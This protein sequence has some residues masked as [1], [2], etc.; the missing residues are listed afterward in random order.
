MAEL[1]QDHDDS[2]PVPIVLIDQDS[3]TNATVVELSFGDRLGA[4]L[5]T[6]LYHAFDPLFL[7]MIHFE[8]TN[9]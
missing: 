5:D 4:L 2:V 9:E 3:D 8:F 7:L 6:V 1:S